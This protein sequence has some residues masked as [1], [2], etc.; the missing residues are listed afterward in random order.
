MRIGD[1]LTAI[2]ILVGIVSVVSFLQISFEIGLT[3][4]SFAIVHYYRVI[5]DNTIG[6]PA[7]LISIEL[8]QRLI[9]F[10]SISFVGASAYCRVPNIDQSRA[11]RITNIPC[12]RILL[13]FI[14]G[15]FGFGIFVFYAALSP[16]TYANEY[17]EEKQDLSRAAIRNLLSIIVGVIVFFFL[18]A[19]FPYSPLAS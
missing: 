8:P 9:D 10:W 2:S 6:L 7:K 17:M 11:L 18:N 1:V 5:A 16:L 19:F 15:I 3:K 14:M 13:F 12:W 4:L